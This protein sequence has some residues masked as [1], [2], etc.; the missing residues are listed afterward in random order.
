MSTKTCP[1]VGSQAVPAA[2]LNAQDIEEQNMK[3][4]CALKTNAR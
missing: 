3:R 1:L 4:A 2:E